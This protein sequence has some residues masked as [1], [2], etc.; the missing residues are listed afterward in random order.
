VDI[1]DN[2]EQL[3][4]IERVNMLLGVEESVDNN[5][6]QKTHK[7]KTPSNKVKILRIPVDKSILEGNLM[8]LP[9]ISY[10]KTKEPLTV[11]EYFWVD[12]KGTERKIE[13]RGSKW[14]VPNEY[15]FDVLTA[16][17][18]LH[19]KQNKSV[20]FNIDENRWN[21]NKTIHFS[22]TELAK[23]MGYKSFGKNVFDKLDI[24]LETLND[25]TIYNKANGAFLDT[26]SNTYL[27][28]EAKESI[29][30]I[31]NYKSYRYSKL[32]EGDKRINYRNIKDFTS[33]T[34][35]DFIYESLCNSYFKIFN[36]EQFQKLDMGIA[37]KIFLLLNKW[38]S[39][40]HKV[41][42]KWETLYQRIPLISTNKE[43]EKPDKY[44]KRRI[45]DACKKLIEVGFVEK[46]HENTIGVEFIFD[47]KAKNELAI[48][49][50][51]E[52]LRQY[53][54][55]SGILNALN[56]INLTTEQIESILNNVSI[57]MIKKTL[58]NT[59]YL[60]LEDKRKSIL[61]L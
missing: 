30:I 7:G 5:K 13:V 31:R 4:L 15:C 52:E 18:R 3:S 27:T 41:F 28:T 55:L 47:D 58:R 34:I 38:R 19:I 20:E 26:K 53:D 61:E 10:F 11:V 50:D 51:D 8:E 49:V 46:V 21:M 16:L 36:Y 48:T 54:T 25:T 44:K 22:L 35:D 33:V 14:G 56:N 6:I 43:E 45:R 37:K 42:L 57:D 12:S 32:K 39:E 9:F 1:V 60:S 2:F 29:G 17:F 40:R 59:H 23:E 24:A